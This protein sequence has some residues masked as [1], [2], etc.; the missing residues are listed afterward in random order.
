[1][2]W[3]K[4]KT[5][6]R[7]PAGSDDRTTQIRLPLTQR[8]NSKTSR[9]CLERKTNTSSQD[10]D[11]S[12][13]PTGCVR[14]LVEGVD[15]AP[16]FHQKGH[17]LDLANTGADGDDDLEA[18][19]E[20]AGTDDMP[21]DTERRGAEP[22]RRAEMMMSVTETRESRSF[23]HELLERTSTVGGCCGRGEIPRRR[24]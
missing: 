4:T 17:A 14:D 8:T 19:M 23:E 1:L 21:M 2:R 16:A 13:I 18:R 3:T 5:C 24:T 10:R 11:T 22:G 20:K 6:T 7:W 15:D 12:K 9:F